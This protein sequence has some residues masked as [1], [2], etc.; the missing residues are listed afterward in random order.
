M[1]N[2]NWVSWG[3][4]AAGGFA[5]WFLGGLDGLTYALI[6]FAAADYITGVLCAIATKTLSSEA[7][8]RGIAKKVM[9]FVIVGMAHIIDTHLL[10]GGSALRT[11]AICFYLANESISLIE[12]A[13]LIG[14]PVPKKLTDILAQIN[15]EGK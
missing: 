14:L 12:N 1:N 2:F 5:G 8:A 10:D 3:F 11:A 6:A 7:G 13:A 9:I 4:G 15:K